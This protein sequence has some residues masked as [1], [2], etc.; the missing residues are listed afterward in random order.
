MT[1]AY[2]AD[3]SLRHTCA[4]RVVNALTFIVII[5]CLGLWITFFILFK[6]QVIAQPLSGNILTNLTCL[7]FFGGLL[8]TLFVGALIGNFLRRTFWTML[9]KRRK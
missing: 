2:Q 1:V 7:I 8:V 9:V 4:G 5:F 3:R 6:D